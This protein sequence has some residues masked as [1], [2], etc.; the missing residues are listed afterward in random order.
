MS[1]LHP[2]IALRTRKTR[3]SLIARIVLVDRRTPRYLP[4]HLLRVVA[5]HRHCLEVVRT[6]AD[7]RQN[8]A[9]LRP[10]VDDLCVYECE[11]TDG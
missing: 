6:E 5:D 10:L 4:L 11:L 1:P 9:H 8:D 3:K 7:E 2:D